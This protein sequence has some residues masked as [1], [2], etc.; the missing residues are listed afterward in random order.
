MASADSARDGGFLS[1]DKASLT[2]KALRG[3]GV[4]Q[5]GEGNPL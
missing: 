2:A 1:E 4:G 5:E 3:A